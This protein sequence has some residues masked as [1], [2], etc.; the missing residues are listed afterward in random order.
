MRKVMPAFAAV[1]VGGRSA[2]AVFGDAIQFVL[3]RG[4]QTTKAIQK[5]VSELMPTLCDDRE[6]FTVKGERYGRTWKRRF[7]HA[8]LHLKR[9]GVVAYNAGTKTWSLTQP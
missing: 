4:P 2:H 3:A 8:Q 9:K 1:Q 5:E 6:F 7:R